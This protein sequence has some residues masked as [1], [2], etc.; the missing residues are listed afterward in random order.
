MEIKCV[1]YE[2]K[3]FIG[4]SFCRQTCIVIIVKFNKEMFFSPFYLKVNEASVTKINGF[5]FFKPI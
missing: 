1:F 2:T 4:V 3:F 5:I